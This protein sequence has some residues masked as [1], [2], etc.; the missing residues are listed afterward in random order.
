MRASTTGA[1]KDG[2]TAH[3]EDDHYDDLA[4]LFPGS[5]AGESCRNDCGYVFPAEVDEVAGFDCP[6]RGHDHLPAFVRRYV[7]WRIEDTS[8]SEK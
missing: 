5:Y 8:E 1:V 6:D 7:Y 2:G 4:E 3:L